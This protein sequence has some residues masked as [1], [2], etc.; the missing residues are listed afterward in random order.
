MFH[1]S[2]KHGGAG[3]LRAAAEAMAELGKQL[4]HPLR[5]LLLTYVSE[6]GPC[7]FSELVEIAGASQAQVGNHLTLLRSAGLL[8]TERHGRQSL[9]RMPNADLAEL[10]ANF[11]AAAGVPAAD[12]PGALTVRDEARC[13]YDHVG[14]RLGVAVLRTLLDRGAVT[15]DPSG[16]DDLSPGSSADAVLSEFGVTDWAQLHGS[17]RRFAYGCPDWTEKAPH[18]GGALGAAVAAS[19][20]ERRWTKPRSGSRALDLTPR[21]RNALRE[22]GVPV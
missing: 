6:H 7:A 8:V 2:M 4:A 13:C 1:A 11:G 10:L 20:R 5:M 19:L 16:T 18:L 17:R 14:G 22:L 21:G 15:G 12:R 3:A 9:Y